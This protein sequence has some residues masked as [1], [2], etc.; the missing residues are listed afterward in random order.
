[1]LLNVAANNVSIW[2]LKM[3][4]RERHIR[5]SVTKP[6]A[7]LNVQRHKTL[8][9]HYVLCTLRFVTV[10]VLWCCTLCDVYVLK[11]VRFGTLTLCAATFCNITS[12]DVYV[13]LLY[14]YVATSPLLLAL[15]PASRIFFV[16][17]AIEA[18]NWIC[19]VPKQIS[20]SL[21]VQQSVLD[22]KMASHPLSEMD[23][24][25]TLLFLPVPPCWFFQSEALLAN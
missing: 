18:Q 16:Y 13:M 20:F 14:I 17:L 22:V 21:Q 10:C 3:S 7:S 11:T 6:T 25:S 9:A 2:N 15:E 23:C 5:Y 12:C 4:K 19:F 24:T 1:M 8:S